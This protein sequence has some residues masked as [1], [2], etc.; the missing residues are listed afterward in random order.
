M[1]ENKIRNP[2]DNPGRRRSQE[3]DDDDIDPLIGKPRMKILKYPN[4]AEDIMGEKRMNHNGE[5]DY[6]KMIINKVMGNH[7]V[8]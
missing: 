2:L 6:T 8:K 4:I 5:S 3:Q 7:S 1:E